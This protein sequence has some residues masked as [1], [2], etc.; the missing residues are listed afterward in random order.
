VGPPEL[1]QIIQK[2]PWQ[3]HKPLL[4]AFASDTQQHIGA[5]DR[6]DFQGRGF[7]YT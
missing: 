3:W 4:V 1:T 5:V 7:A 6:A 2:R